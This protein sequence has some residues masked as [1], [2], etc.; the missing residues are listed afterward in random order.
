MARCIAASAVAPE[1][2][3]AALFQLQLV[4]RDGCGYYRYL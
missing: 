4:D 1:T 2:D 3:I